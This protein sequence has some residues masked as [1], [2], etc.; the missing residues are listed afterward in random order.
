[1]EKE[2]LDTIFN[3]EETSP[4]TMLKKF[5]ELRYELQ[6]YVVENAA[7]GEKG[8]KG[9]EGLNLYTT[10]ARLSETSG[11]TSISSLNIPIGRTVK[12]GDLIL[13][14]NS[15]SNGFVNR[16]TSIKGDTLNNTNVGNIRGPQGPKDND[17]TLYNIFN[18]PHSD[19]SH[20]IPMDGFN[21]LYLVYS[22]EGKLVDM[23]EVIFG[24][25]EMFDNTPFPGY[26]DSSISYIDELDVIH[27]EWEY[28]P[29]S[30]WKSNLIIYRR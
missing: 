22:N 7:K 11:S 23:N 25:K 30:G 21:E 9:D 5:R 12:V 29:T 1:M 20:E 6:D 26:L 13:S 17:Y 24:P 3:N 4:K 28:N 14:T 18:L 10:T 2:I 27:V 16:I 15:L 8:D 19:D